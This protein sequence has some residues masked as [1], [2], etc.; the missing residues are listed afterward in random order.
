MGPSFVTLLTLALPLVGAAPSNF[1]K[2]AG[3]CS[4]RGYDNGRPE[5]YF[6]SQSTKYRSVALCGAHCASDT[7]C[8][9]FGFG[10]NECLHYTATVYVEFLTLL[11]AT[12]VRGTNRSTEPRTSVPLTAVLISSPIS[13]ACPGA[14]HPSPAAPAV[15]RAE[16]HPVHQTVVEL[17]PLAVA[18]SHPLL[19]EDR[20]AAAQVSTR[21][22]RSCT[23]PSA[24]TPTLPAARLSAWAA[25]AVSAL[26]SPP[27]LVCCTSTLL[28]PTSIPLSA[29]RTC[30]MML[31]ALPRVRL[32]RRPFLRRL[33]WL[34]RLH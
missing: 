8:V 6:W 31:R 32:P 15:P 12:L 34:R 19:L 29:A 33:Q 24:R 2:R 25:V 3:S 1:Q 23:T 27:R 20:L 28:R 16:R 7:S 4:V 21:K 13:L 17:H 26:D 9:S 10:N 30:F 14:H 22:K 11:T 18:R 5:A